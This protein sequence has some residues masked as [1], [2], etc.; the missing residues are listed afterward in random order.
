MKGR[1]CKVLVR[2]KMNSC[3]VEFQ[4]GQ[5][6]VISRNALRKANRPMGRGNERKTW[7]HIKNE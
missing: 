4:N 7:K 5:L 6:E 1:K 3:M 2:G